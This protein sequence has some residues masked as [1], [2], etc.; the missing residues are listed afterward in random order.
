MAAVLA[1][2][3]T[4][5]AVI[6]AAAQAAP[7]EKRILILHSYHNGYEWTDEQGAG[8]AEAIGEVAGDTVQEVHH[9]DW[10][11]YPTAANLDTME[12]LL[13]ARLDG[14]AVDVVVTTDDAALSFALRLRGQWLGNVPVVFSGV[15]SHTARQLIGGEP[16]VTGVFET[17]DFEGT[18]R[19]A[20]EA[21]PG[22][23]KIYFIRDDTESAVGQEFEFRKSLDRL[24]FPLERHI[25]AGLPLDSLLE[26]LASLPPDAAAMIGSYADDGQG[27]RADQER[28]AERM[29]QRSAVPIFV[30]QDTLMNHGVLG[31][32]LLSPREHGRAAGMLAGNLLAGIA[33]DEL[34]PQAQR[35]MLK[36]VDFQQ[37]QRFNLPLERF[38]GLDRVINKPFSFLETYRTLVLSVCAVIIVLSGMIIGLVLVIRQRWRAEAALSDANQKLAASRQRLE[39]SVGNLVDSQRRLEQSKQHLRL[40]AESA[41]DILWNW[42]VRQDV[43]SLS[44]RIKEV[45]GYQESDVT[46]RDSWYRLIHPD[47]R[48][49]AMETLRRHLQGELPEY[50]AE[51]RV[52]HRDGHFVWLLATGKTLFDEQRRATVMAGSYTDITAERQRQDRLDRMA[53]FDPLTGLPNRASLSR[54]VDERI[55]AD[56]AGGKS[57]DLAL[58]FLDMDNFKFIN[59]SF[60]HRAGD[61]VLIE[62]GERLQ[63]TVGQEVFVSRL[64]GDEFVIV[65]QGDRAADAQRIARTLEQCLI[66]PFVVEGQNFFV[67]SSIGIARYPWDGRSFDELLQN[68]DTAM[69][70]SKDNGRSRVTTFTPDMNRNVVERVRLLNR[71]RAAMDTNAFALHYQPQV[72]SG[73]GTIRGFEALLRWTDRELGV[74]SPARFIPACE[75]TGMIIPLGLWVLETACAQAVRLIGRGT[76]DLTMSVNV[77]VVQLSQGDFVPAVLRILEKTGLAPANLELEITES[78]MIASL[79]SAV[80]KLEE[81]RK[82]G[83]HLALDDFGTGYSSLTY[84]RRLPIHTLKLD[85][86]FIDEVHEK[87]DARGMVASIVRIARDLSHSVVAEGV[88]DMA[89]W[90]ALARTGCDVIQGYVVNRPLPADKLDGFLAAWE[91]RRVALPLLTGGGT[92]VGLPGRPGLH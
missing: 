17:R 65:L 13:R 39:E 26:R 76:T 84:L 16:N 35:S 87:A 73:D 64:G 79:D 38:S 58:L 83:I 86:G 18:I 36:I 7:R 88:E 24:K 61:Q 46:T 68:A 85:K 32:S 4:L 49:P 50:R 80:R 40:V 25:L 31:G 21:N 2:A 9:L 54:H 55:A 43:R 15:V 63:R 74:V 5:A 22:L 27:V 69:Y 1:L 70:C 29:S 11:R 28:L 34:P 66:A 37:A 20:L 12:N 33:I 71:M 51:Y 75:E 72:H 10:K 6:P 82:A 60:G 41:R 59:D 52:R 67:S 44:G 42:D 89:Q 8:I 30:L 48:G 53:H 90:E 45:L 92:V 78:L 62:F 91:R 77:S 57:H 19:M 56:K 47:D 3:M 23:Q 14:K 81:L